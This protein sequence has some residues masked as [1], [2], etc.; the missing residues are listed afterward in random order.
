MDLLRPFKGGWASAAAAATAPAPATASVDTSLIRERFNFDWATSDPVDDIDTYWWWA[1]SIR[2]DPDEVIADDGE[3]NIWSVPF[4]TDGTDEITFGTPQRVAETYVPIQAGE[5]QAATAA[6]RRR[7]QRVAASALERPSKPDR[8]NTQAAAVSAPATERT[9]MDAA[10][11][12]ALARLH[13]LDPDTATEDQVNAAVLAANTTPDPEAEIPAGGT[14]EAETPDEAPEPVLVTAT[15]ATDLRELFGLPSTATDEQVVTAARELREGAAAGA[16]VA[17]NAVAAELD[18]TVD[19][20]VS[21]GR[22]A[23]SAR[24]AWR[25]AIDPGQAPDAAATARATSERERLASMAT[26]RVPV[27]ERGTASTAE[28]NGGK[29]ASLTRVLAATTNQGRRLGGAPQEVTRRG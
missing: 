23:P 9:P 22:I 10:V 26:N 13:G 5:G 7:R 8:S 4:T 25:A 27:R 15:Q 11:L 1:R 12:Q 17:R 24:D 18:R 21:D 3:G 6:V 29:P 14:P 28:Q 16:Q 2:V 20:A 19:D